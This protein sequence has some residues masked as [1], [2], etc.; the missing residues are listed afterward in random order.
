MLIALAPGPQSWLSRNRNYVENQLQVNPGTGSHEP[1]ALNLRDIQDRS[2]EFS[3]LVGYHGEP[4]VNL[5]HN[6]R[7]I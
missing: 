4:K 6:I 7:I 1:Q 2:V 5:V 3:L